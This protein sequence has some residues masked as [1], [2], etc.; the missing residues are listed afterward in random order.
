MRK[1]KKKNAESRGIGKKKKKK[2]E[3]EEGR[4]NV[5]KKRGEKNFINVVGRMLS[6]PVWDGL[7]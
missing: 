7:S 1:R 2:K 5:K 3:E 6:S 4:P